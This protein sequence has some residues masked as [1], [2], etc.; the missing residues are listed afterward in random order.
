MVARMPGGAGQG[1]VYSMSYGLRAALFLI[2]LSA[3]GAEEKKFRSLRRAAKAL[4]LESARVA[5]P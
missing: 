3:P 4:P 2:F 5:D 1:F